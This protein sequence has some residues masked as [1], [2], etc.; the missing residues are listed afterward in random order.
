[1]IGFE[2]KTLSNGMRV[3]VHF[4][5]TTPL[6]VVNLLYDV[7]ARDEAP[8]RTGFAHL[9]EHL[10]F[11]GSVNV[12]EFDMM[13]QDAGGENNAFTTN[14][15]TNYYITVPAQNLE[16]AF[17]LESDR[18]LGLSFS[19][20]K[21]RVQ[22]NV[23]VEEFRES[24]LNQP[25]G[26]VWMLLRSLAY[27]VHPYQWST[28]GKSIDHIQQATLDEVKGF[29]DRHYHP[30]NAV[31][32]VAGNV[33]AQEVF[34]L[35]HKWFGDI[36]GRELPGRNLAIEPEQNQ[37]R[38]LRVER[39][40]P[41]HQLVMSFPCPARQD[42]GFYAADLLSDVL[43]NGSSSRLMLQLVKKTRLFSEINAYL[44]GSIDPGQFLV[45]G[46]LT[47]GVSPEQAEE[48]VWQE[49]EK[50][51]KYPLSGRELEKV[52]N[53]VEASQIFSESS[54]LAKA[55]NLAYY[56]LLGDANLINQQMDHYFAQTSQSLQQAA[57]MLFQPQKA[58]VLH[59]CARNNSGS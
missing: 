27:Q 41:F 22:K 40:V 49:L 48:A 37:Q 53:K 25:Y 32:S 38:R 35:A 50:L 9:F 28:I 44:T 6:A 55:M 59:Y 12:S 7:G 19:E 57:G 14:D 10:M 13:L 56:E 43:A 15:L 51:I 47:E 54:V 24:F 29:F 30:G 4:D 45:S 31:L 46:K 26:D 3:L 2:K 52:K 1:M 36:P 42:P 58:S 39:D 23:V 11:E 8:H 18:L 17:W 5:P 20:E 21:L 16:T 34:E 33:Q